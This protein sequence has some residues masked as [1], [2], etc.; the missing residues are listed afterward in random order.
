MKRPTLSFTKEVCKAEIISNVY[1]LPHKNKGSGWGVG[2][3]LTNDKK[4]IRKS[5]FQSYWVDFGGEYDFS[6]YTILGEGEYIWFGLFTEHWGHF[7]IDNISRLWYL[8]SKDI[9]DAKILYVSKSGN[10]ISGNFLRLMEL[11]GIKSDNLVLV[12]KPLKVDK[13]ILPEY[14]KSDDHYNEQFLS[15]FKKISESEFLM[16]DQ[17]PEK[18]YFSRMKFKDAK[19][20]ELG[21]EQLEDFF[22]KNGYV[23]LYPEELSLD[24][25]INIWKSSKNIACING[26]IPLNICFS[27]GNKPD[28]TVL[29]KTSLAHENLDELCQM[30]DQNI[31]YID[32][33]SRDFAGKVHS[34]GKGPFIMEVTPELIN[35]ANENDLLLPSVNKR[36][37]ELHKNI[38]FYKVI[39]KNKSFEFIKKLIAILKDKS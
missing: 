5:G 36:N 1:V 15:I 39:I 7:L 14:S 25:Q 9:A 27:M 4:Y 17:V 23:I 2:G 32:V 29:N 6:D 11:L 19:K 21:E 12:N 30:F 22:C 37:S 18:V 33:Y 10:K 38:F 26:T 20:K 24:T 28:I 16:I 3:L 13:I 35:F 31:R 8:N 34:I